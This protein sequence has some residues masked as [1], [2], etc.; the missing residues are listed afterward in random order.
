MH[1]AITGYEENGKSHGGNQENSGHERTV[2]GR[3]DIAG[4]DLQNPRPWVLGSAALLTKW[5]QDPRGS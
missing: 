5:P 3:A 2:E 4:C 1:I